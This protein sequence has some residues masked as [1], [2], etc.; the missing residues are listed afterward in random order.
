MIN[1]E[2]LARSQSEK[3]NRGELA[4][5]SLS[6]VLTLAKGRGSEWATFRLPEDVVNGTLRITT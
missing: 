2:D 6:P 4:R 3:E 1:G 5:L